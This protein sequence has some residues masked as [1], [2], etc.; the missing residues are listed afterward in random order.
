MVDRTWLGDG[1]GSNNAS[2]P[3][4]WSPTGVPQSGDILR[5]AIG[6]T[7]TIIVSGDALAGD[8]FIANSANLSAHLT[9]HAVM[10]AN[11][12]FASGT[13]YVDQQSTLNLS[14]DRSPA[15]INL[16]GNSTLNLTG[17]DRVDMTI[18]IF[19]DDAATLHLGVGGHGGNLI[20]NLAAGARWSGLLVPGQASPLTI[21]GGAGSEFINNGASI[22]NGMTTIGVDVLGSG[23]ID[24]L[25]GDGFGGMVEFARSVSASQQVID[26]SHVLIDAP[27][28]FHAGLTLAFADATLEG[29]TADSYSLGNGLL[30]LWEGQSIVDT[31]K[32]TVQNDPS[33]PQPPLFGVSQVAGGIDI[34]NNGPQTGGT[35]LGL[36]V[37][38]PPA[39]P[40]PAPAPT[41]TPPVAPPPAPVAHN[42]GVTDTTTGAV[43]FQAGAPYAGPVAGLTNE[44]ILTT[45]DSL[46]IAATVPN[47]FIHTG[48]GNDAISVAAGNNVLDGSTGSNFLVGGTG[49][50]TFFVDDRSPGADIWSTVVGFHAGDAAT[51]WGVTQAGFTLNWADGEGAA[52]F[53]GLTAH[54]M[55]PDKP[56]ASITFAG[57]TTADLAAGGRLQ[58]AFGATVDQPGAPGSAFMMVTGT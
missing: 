38:P 17:E 43:S 1:G 4:D 49:A 33:F 2:N 32:L 52:G 25:D 7:K 18:N 13:F 46:N 14:D 50:D 48:S 44:I 12:T 3:D 5:E 23:S 30:T 34:H 45:S 53:T 20:V 57:Y 8:T 31:V 36:H 6:D 42:F 54:F 21:N 19:G 11:L 55:A 22:S 47:S 58:A 16:S 10:T 40:T 39:V 27:A 35:L 28:D 56:I 24:A 41:P 15:T 29:L 37:T 51:V 9:D 26:H